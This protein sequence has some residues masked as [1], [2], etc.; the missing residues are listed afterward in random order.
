MRAIYVSLG[1][2]VVAGCGGFEGLRQ[3]MTTPDP[4]TGQTPFGGAVE[5]I[6]SLVTNPADPDAWMKIA[7]AVIAAGVGLFG[8]KKAVD[9]VA[10]KK[11]AESAK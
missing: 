6:P 8:A 2:L 7:G 4:L 5:A 11:V 1:A 10:K 3:A 9:H